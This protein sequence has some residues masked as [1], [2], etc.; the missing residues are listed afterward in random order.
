MEDVAASAPLEPVSIVVDN[1]A[2]IASALL[3]SGSYFGMLRAD[4]QVGRVINT[5]RPCFTS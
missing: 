5:L 1:A 3:V 4:A 2:E